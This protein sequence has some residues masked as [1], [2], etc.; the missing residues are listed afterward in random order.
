MTKRQ[1]RSAGTLPL[2]PVQDDEPIVAL[3]WVLQSGALAALGQMGQ[4][5]EAARD[6]ERENPRTMPGD[7]VAWCQT[8]HAIPNGAGWDIDHL[9]LRGQRAARTCQHVRMGTTVPRLPATSSSPDT[10]ARGR[11]ATRADARRVHSPVTKGRITTGRVGIFAWHRLNVTGAAARR[12]TPDVPAA[13]RVSRP[14]VTTAGVTVPT[15]VDAHLAGT[16]NPGP[17]PCFPVTGQTLANG[18]AAVPADVA[19]ANR[20]AGAA[21]AR[22]ARAAKR[23]N[24]E[25]SAKAKRADVL[26]DLALLADLAH[27]G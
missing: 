5:W 25:T 27:Q 2:N 24:A 20:A 12:A 26:A 23:A 7:D 3:G 15:A 17:W 1:I 6:A 18:R 10:M 11:W 13:D 22:A 19:K 4:T 16:G 14:I 21:K 9:P 8:C